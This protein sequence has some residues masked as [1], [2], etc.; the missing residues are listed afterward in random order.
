MRTWTQR[1]RPLRAELCIAVH[2]STSLMLGSAFSC[3]AAR[4]SA[5]PA[6]GGGAVRGGAARG[7]CEEE[8]EKSNRKSKSSKCAED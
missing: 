7:A 8:D 3:A 6:G 5:L 1:L 2:P 4:V